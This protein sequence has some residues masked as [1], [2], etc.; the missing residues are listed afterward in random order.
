MVKAVAASLKPH[1]REVLALPAHRSREELGNVVLFASNSPLGLRPAVDGG[2]KDGVD[3]D[4]YYWNPSANLGW[5]RRFEP[6]T[7]GVA[8][9]TDDL[10]PVDLWSEEVN[11]VA[12][13]DLHRYFN[14][15]GL[16]SY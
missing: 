15:Q 5:N 13:K 7:R 9:L 10:N 6:D 12:R 4:G 8:I 16:S 14:E 11:F 2:R 3:C 1:F